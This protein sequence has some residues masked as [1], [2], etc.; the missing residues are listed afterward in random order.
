[1]ARV[2]DH[3]RPAAGNPA[4]RPNDA[5]GRRVMHMDMQPEMTNELAIAILQEDVARSERDLGQVRDFVTGNGDP[6]KGLLWLCADLGKLVATM[7]QLM[8]E[9]QKALTDHV[10]QGHPR[11]N[12]SPWNWNRPAFEAAKQVVGYIVLGVLILLAIGTITYIQTGRHL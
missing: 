1:A 5:A 2:V 9:Q 10:N 3:G 7:S 6:K 8:S 4:C 11:R 12:E